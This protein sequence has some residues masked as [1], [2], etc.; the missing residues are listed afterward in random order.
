[1]NY[2]ELFC[3]KISCK[4][5]DLKLILKFVDKTNNKME[6]YSMFYLEIKKKKVKKAEEKQ[7]KEYFKN[8]HDIVI[9]G[10]YFNDSDK[11]IYPK[12]ISESRKQQVINYDD[13]I[14]YTDIF[15]GGNIKTSR[16]NSCSCWWRFSWSCWGFSWCWNRWKRI[17]F[18]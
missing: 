3:V 8:N 9:G 7:I 12:S 4:D 11:N 2:K 17:Y 18:H 6:E 5:T 14:S 1:M 13:L 16:N 15:V 10:I